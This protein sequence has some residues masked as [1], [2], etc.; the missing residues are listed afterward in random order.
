MMTM[1]TAVLGGGC[2]WCLEAAFQGLK[3]LKSVTPGYA[4]GVVDNPTYE[5]VCSGQT[6][7]AEVIR[8]EWDP[9]VLSFET[10]LRLFFVVH[11]PTT[12]NRQGND[13]G[14]QYRSVIFY[15]TA[16]QERTARAVMDE[17]TRDNLWG[18]P[19]VTAIVPAAPFWPAEEKHHNYYARNPQAGYCQVVIAPKVA[20]ARTVFGSLFR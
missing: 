1:E 19:P 4:G 2:F 9:A 3:G 13:I 16:E 7:H 17:I 6:G 20:K 12:L 10:L 11:D 18:R 14:T 5:Q 15:Q 8:L